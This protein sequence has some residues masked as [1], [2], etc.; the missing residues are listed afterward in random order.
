MYQNIRL[1]GVPMGER[2]VGRGLGMTEKNKK[3]KDLHRSMMTKCHTEEY[4]NSTFG[5]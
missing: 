2:E 4:M 1:G 5:T 3:R